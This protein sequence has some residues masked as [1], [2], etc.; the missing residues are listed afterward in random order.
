MSALIC[1]I[2]IAQG[3]LCMQSVNSKGKKFFSRLSLPNTVWVPNS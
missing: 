3:R 1:L 2:G